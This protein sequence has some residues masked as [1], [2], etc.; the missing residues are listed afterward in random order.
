MISAGH[1]S[2]EVEVRVVDVDTLAEVP[3]GQPGELWFRTPQLM[4]GYHNKPE[5]TAA[6]ITDDGW[7]RTGDIGRLDDE[8]FIFV[9]DRL[10]DMIISGGENIY[11]VEVERVLTDHPAV[12]GAAVFGIPDDKWGESVQAVVELSGGAEASEAELIAWCQERLARYKCPRSVEIVAVLPRNPAGKLLKRDL[13]APYWE[14]RG[15]AI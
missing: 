9:E 5:A 15:R 1:P 7:F 2:R 12:L 4:K 8:G 13:R 11:S 10:K 14:N 6:T 3:I